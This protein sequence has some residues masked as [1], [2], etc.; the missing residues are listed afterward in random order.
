MQ[1]YK[2][3]RYI[4]FIL[5]FSV[6][7]FCDD[8]MT[9][10]QFTRV[11]SV[12]S[13]ANLS[14]STNGNI[15]VYVLDP[16]TNSIAQPHYKKG[17]VASIKVYVQTWV[18]PGVP[19]NYTQLSTSFSLSSTNYFPGLFINNITINN[20]DGFVEFVWASD[21]E[22]SDFSYI[23]KMLPVAY[24]NGVKQEGNQVY[25]NESDEFGLF[26]E[27]ASKIKIAKRT[28]A[29]GEKPQIFLIQVFC[30]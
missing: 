21:Y 6:F 19:I 25:S 26:F 28:V 23:V 27:T 22:A 10:S 15:P 30:K 5:L 17:L 24:I 11:T 3:I 2:N 20:A 4:L 29:S 14:F 1:K 16:M 12:T 7:A 9:G 18:N 8:V 13:F